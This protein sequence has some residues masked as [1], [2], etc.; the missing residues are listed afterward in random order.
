MFV[1][2]NL[3][4]LKLNQDRVMTMQESIFNMLIGK[5]INV[6]DSGPDD[7]EMMSK[8]PLKTLESLNELCS[9]ILDDKGLQ[10]LVRQ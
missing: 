7:E 1:I 6:L 2:K 3:T 8:L 5:G 4:T 10:K 9:Q